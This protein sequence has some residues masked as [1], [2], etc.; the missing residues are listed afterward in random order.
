[1]AS[2]TYFLEILLPLPCP[3][4]FFTSK[5][6]LSPLSLNRLFGLGVWF[7]LRVREVPGSNPGGAHPTFCF[8]KDHRLEYCYFEIKLHCLFVCLV[9]GWD[10]SGL[11]F[12]RHKRNWIKLLRHVQNSGQIYRSVHTSYGQ[13]L[14]SSDSIMDYRHT[15]AKSLI[16]IQIPIPG[17]YRT[18]ANMVT[19]WLVHTLSK[20]CLSSRKKSP[21]ITIYQA[22]SKK[23]LNLLIEN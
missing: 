5:I 11:Y 10:F 9:R 22:T 6:I 1:M 17:K 14:L 12:T 16:Q 20:I 3:S 21:E 23:A 15:M 2:R 18:I 13:T 8:F 4:D 19:S 7:S